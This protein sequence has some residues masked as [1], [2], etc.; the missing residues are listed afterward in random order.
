MAIS[1]S[2]VRAFMASYFF[3]I[4]SKRGKASLVISAMAPPSRGMAQ[5]MMTESSGLMRTAKIV[6]R[7]SIS[8]ERASSRIII[9]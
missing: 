4:A 7:I 5:R 8:G 1:V 3:S 2:C 9:W 6:A